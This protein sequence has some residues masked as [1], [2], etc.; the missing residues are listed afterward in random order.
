MIT[1]TKTSNR[2][3]P[4]AGRDAAMVLSSNGL[5]LLNRTSLHALTTRNPS[6]ILSSL[7]AKIE[8]VPDALKKISR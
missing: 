1:R 3:R 2:K 5:L 8:K 7:W 6:R 4:R